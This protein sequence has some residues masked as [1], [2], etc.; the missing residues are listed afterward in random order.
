[1]NFFRK[2]LILLLF[3]PT[4]SFAENMDIKVLLCENQSQFTVEIK[5]TFRG[6]GRS[7][8]LGCSLVTEIEG[9]KYPLSG[10]S[11]TMQSSIPGNLADLFSEVHNV[12][13]FSFA[14]MD[15]GRQVEYE[16]FSVTC[17][18]GSFFVVKKDFKGP[19]TSPDYLRYCSKGRSEYFSSS[20]VHQGVYESKL[21]STIEK[22]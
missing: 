3:I 5:K 4:F 2:S 9:I 22:N 8:A 17:S 14:G 19:G 15:Y 20:K 6:P 12:P 18:F 10:K 11:I 1:M 16:A 7:A 13:A 21:V